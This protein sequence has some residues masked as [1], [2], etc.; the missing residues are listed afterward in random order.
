MNLE[1]IN[2]T[3]AS[4]GEFVVVIYMQNSLTQMKVFHDV[5]SLLSCVKELLTEKKPLYEGGVGVLP[6]PE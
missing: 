1:K 2:I 3:K 5:E 6:N 4:D